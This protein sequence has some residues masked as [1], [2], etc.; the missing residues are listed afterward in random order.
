[1]N[2]EQSKPALRFGEFVVLMALMI[3]LVALSIDTMLPALSTIGH[4]L[5]VQRPNDNQLII[6]LLLLGLSVGQVIYGPLSDS[7][8]RK[9]AIYAGFA[10]FI[11]GTLVALFS[12]NFS[13]MLAG[14]LLQGVGAAG[15]RI[16]SMALI[17][18]QYQGRD[19]A[20]VMSFVMAVFILVPAVGPLFGQT[21]LLMAHW[22]AI[23]G[24]FLIMA[25][26]AVTWFAIRQPET[27]SPDRRRPFSLYRIALA[28]RE[29]VTNRLALGCTIAAGLV[30]GGF[31]GYLNSAQQIFQNQYGLGQLFPLYFSALAL[32]IG[33]ASFLNARLVVRFGMRALSS[34]A[35]Q[36]IA[37]LSLLFFPIAFLLSGQP[38]LWLL[39]IYLIVSFFCIGLLFGNLNTMAME[40]LGH[41]AGIGAAVIGSLSTFIAVMMGLVIGQNYNGTVLP[42]VGGFA[43]LGMAALVVLRWAVGAKT[44]SAEAVL[45]EGA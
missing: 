38:P 12:R 3:S 39:M 23:F 18:D 44:V 1:M 22:R 10:L 7:T 2:T 29:I 33:S 14:R 27:L 21:I 9:P 31:M 11:V 28:I 16:V 37:G 45:E 26:I 19:M 34:R 25:L 8:G 42:L 40:P 6:S 35:M 30:F 5:G 13:M 32:A 20:R 24:V 41:I 36:T 4:D 17:R 15:P 43:V